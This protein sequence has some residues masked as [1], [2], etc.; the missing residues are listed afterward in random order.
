MKQKY[1]S[2]KE[3]A[4]IFSVSQNTI[5]SSIRANKDKIKTVKI[6]SCIRYCVEDFEKV[7]ILKQ[8]DY[9]NLLNNILS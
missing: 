6:K 7:H 9:T 5:R 2:D 3:L 8:N 4:L 1:L